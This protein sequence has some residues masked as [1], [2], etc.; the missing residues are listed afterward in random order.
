[1][2][3]PTHR[4]PPWTFQATDGPSSCPGAGSL[5]CP[6]GMLVD[7]V[8]RPDSWTH[9]LGVA[10]APPSPPRCRTPAAGLG[11]APRPSHGGHTRHLHG[12]IATWHTQGLPDASCA[13]LHGVGR[14]PAGDRCAFPLARRTREA[15]VQE[16][17]GCRA[18]AEA[19]LCGSQGGEVSCG[20]GGVCR[21]VGWGA[22]TAGR[23]RAGWPS[24]PDPRSENRLKCH[25]L[26]C[27]ASRSPGES[28]WHG[29]QRSWT[30]QPHVCVRQPCSLRQG[31]GKPPL[32]REGFLGLTLT[33]SKMVSG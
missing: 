11:S 20:Q 1:M 14:P 9:A 8:L 13:P 5:R 2:G 6:C 10:P 32:S 31:W 22:E 18:L 23:D 28:T 33:H 12:G 24:A 15:R 4:Y 21:A 16:S 27:P 26:P 30:P 17:Q 3:A 19:E 7:I 25:V 29:G